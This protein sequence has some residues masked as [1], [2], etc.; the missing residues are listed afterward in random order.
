MSAILC[1]CVTMEIY[2]RD[3]RVEGGREGKNNS[4]E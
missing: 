3:T 2:T 4:E 1:V